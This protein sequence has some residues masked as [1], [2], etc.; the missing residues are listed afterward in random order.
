METIP[1]RG[2]KEYQVALPPRG[3]RGKMV[4]QDA[5][6]RRPLLSVKGSTNKD[7]FVF[8]DKEEACIANRNCPEAVQI[9]E[10]I[11]KIKQRIRLE[12]RNGTYLMPVWIKESESDDM[13]QTGFA[14]PGKP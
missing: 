7:N 5:P 4:M 9:R 1:N 11:K 10:L 2:E 14:R 3:W 12:E 13:Q 8:F 6:V